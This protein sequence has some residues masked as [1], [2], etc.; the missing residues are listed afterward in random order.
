M[1]RREWSV[2]GLGLSLP[3]PGYL[4]HSW[5]L[6]LL[7]DGDLHVGGDGV[8]IG[9]SELEKQRASSSAA[10]LCAVIQGEVENLGG[11]GGGSQC[12]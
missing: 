10:C 7:S 5:P 11:A 2:S 6:V 12:L 9:L 4:I 8:V 3:P 1:G